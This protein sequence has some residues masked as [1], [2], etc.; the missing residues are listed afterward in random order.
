MSSVMSFLSAASSKSASLFR[1]ERRL[2]VGKMVTS[3]SKST[4]RNAI[5]V[6]KRRRRR[7]S[8]RLFGEERYRRTCKRLWIRY[9]TRKSK[10]FREA[11]KLG[12]KVHKFGGTCVGSSERI[13]GVCDLLIESAKREPNARGRVR[14][15]RDHE[16]RTESYGL[17]DKRDDDGGG[18]MTN[19]WKSWKS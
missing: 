15:G 16:G 7:K 3:S 1:F 18:E 19:T 13:S 4:R 5:K 12:W 6:V 10:S 11:R 14:D 17:L 9:R 2:R 8:S